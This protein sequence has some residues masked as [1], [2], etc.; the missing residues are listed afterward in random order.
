VAHR[1]VEV[2]VRGFGRVVDEARLLRVERV[3]LGQPVVDRV[4]QRLRRASGP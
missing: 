4:V 3:F 2:A 1:G